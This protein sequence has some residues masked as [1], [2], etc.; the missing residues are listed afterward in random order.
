MTT[1]HT[2][3]PW[4]ADGNG[5]H[6]GTRC[7][8][9]THTEPKEQR[10]ADAH[11]IAAAPDLLEALRELREWV[12]AWTPKFTYEPEYGS[13]ARRVYDAIAKAEGRMK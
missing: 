2:P 12:D 7:V 6:K 4:I 3:G 11:L 5:I 1:Q 9:T 8:A 10:D 13:T